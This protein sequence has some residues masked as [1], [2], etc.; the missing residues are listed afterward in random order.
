MSV[1]D[2]ILASE[3]FLLQDHIH[4][5]TVDDLTTFSDHR[6]LTIHLKHKTSVNDEIIK[7]SQTKTTNLTKR[8]NRIKI[9]NNIIYEKELNHIMNTNDINMLISKLDNCTNGDEL[10]KIAHS[11]ASLYKDAAIK[12]N[13]NNK[14]RAKPQNK[15][16]KINKNQ[17]YNH[18]CRT[19]KRK[20][21]QI[22][23]SLNRNPHKQETRILFYKTKKEYNK[24]LR[25]LKR[26]YEERITDKMEKL[27]NE[28]K[29]EFW[30]FLKSLKIGVLID[31]WHDVKVFQ[32]KEKPC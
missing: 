10:N 3:N 21:N 17:W 30:K 11:V 14:P 24:L 20:L 26:N 6:P 23:K 16:K 27:Y 31:I 7:Q 4:S 18:D 5:F 12:I 8:P 9:E 28:D 15:T 1:V 25:S 29:N 22:T 32:S 19:L 13:T 2:Y